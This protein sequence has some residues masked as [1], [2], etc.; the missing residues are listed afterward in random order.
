MNP[1][2]IIT[3]PL[4]CLISLLGSLVVLGL[5]VLLL[6]WF[7]VGLVLKPL[8]ERHWEGVLAV[9]ASV[10]SAVVQPFRAGLVF[11][12]VEV[13]NPSPFPSEPMLEVDLVSLDTDW[14][15][16]FEK[17]AAGEPLRFGSAEVVIGRVSLLSLNGRSN[18]EILRD[19]WGALLGL[20][21]APNQLHLFGVP[22]VVDRLTLRVQSV[23]E[24]VAQGGRVQTERFAL[25]YVREFSAVSDW[26]PVME[27]LAMDLRVLGR[28]RL[29]EAL[30]P[31]ASIGA[32]SKTEEALRGI[33]EGILGR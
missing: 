10:E 20:P 26:R 27:G 24:G 19:Q 18:L 8:T 22:I 25:N 32:G 23:E 21:D 3:K 12:D 11:S 14:A 13:M 4:G 31:A 2:S 28:V 15:T 29:A 17:R 9:E 6:C 1:F 16:V 30:Y 7:G 33:L 5:M